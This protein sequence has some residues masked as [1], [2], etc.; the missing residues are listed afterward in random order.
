MKYT[1]AQEL[2]LKV[3]T[4]YSKWEAANHDKVSHFTAGM[5]WMLITFL[6]CNIEGWYVWVPSFTVMSIVFYLKEKY[7]DEKTIFR[8]FDWW[9]ILA[10]LFGGFIIVLFITWKYYAS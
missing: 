5:L 9:D 8:R 10:T 7:Y 4:A 6:F 1:K 2:C 3:F